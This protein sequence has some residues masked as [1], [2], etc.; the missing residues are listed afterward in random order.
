MYGFTRFYAGTRPAEDSQYAPDLGPQGLLAAMEVVDPTKVAAREA[1]A[2]Y[3]CIVY[4]PEPLLSTHP[5][6]S[7][8]RGCSPS[9][10]VHPASFTRPSPI[11]PTTAPARWARIVSNDME[12]IPLGLIAAWGSLLCCAN[13]QAHVVLILLFTLA[14][15]GHTVCYAKALIP[16]PTLLA[17]WTNSHN[18]AVGSTARLTDAGTQT[19]QAMPEIVYLVAQP[20]IG[21]PSLGKLPRGP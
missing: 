5:L 8:F 18:R 1:E 9:P 12:N 6:T 10:F 15:I 14:R 4:S 17:A 2:R 7:I 3:P 19:R 21:T 20:L 13:P 11:T 16:S